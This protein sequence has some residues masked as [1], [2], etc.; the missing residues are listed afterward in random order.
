MQTD[1]SINITYPII[2]DFSKIDYNEYIKLIV[3]FDNNTIYYEDNVWK[4]K[5]SGDFHHM[6]LK[7]VI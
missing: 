2:N 7:I 3:P 4:S 6:V 1:G 5:Q